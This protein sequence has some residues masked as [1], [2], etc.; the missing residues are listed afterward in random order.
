MVAR[1]DRIREGHYPP[2]LPAYRI[3]E[4]SHYL[5]IPVSTLRSWVQGRKYPTKAGLKFF[6]PVISLADNEEYLLSFVNLVEAHV[7][8]GIRREHRVALPKVRSALSYLQDE[9]PSK[10][11][12]ADQKFETDGLDLFIEKYG[13]LI[14]ISQS[15][16]LALRHLLEAHL[17]RIERDPSGL[18]TRLYPFTRKGEA[19]DPKVVV[20]DP[21]ISFGQPVL[22][23]TG[24]PTS[25]I[26]GRFKAGETIGELAEDYG[27]QEFEIEEA[28][29]CE[30][31]PQAA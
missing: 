6:E 23:G 10:H 20:I 17:Q 29:R 25:V 26:F 4:A 18:P 8:A 22:V 28:I 7:L 11:P 16:Q 31:E 15:G 3:P 24:I 30:A 1:R 27:R 19:E 2:E 13:Q 21:Y 5:R 14:N 12:L 9:Y